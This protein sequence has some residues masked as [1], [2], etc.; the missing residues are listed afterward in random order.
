MQRQEE[1]ARTI[2][3][4]EVNK[5]LPKQ[6]PYAKWKSAKA[7]LKFALKNKDKLVLLAS[8]C[9]D[10]ETTFLYLVAD[11]PVY[12]STTDLY[13]YKN[14]ELWNAYFAQPEPEEG[15][16]E[17]EYYDPN[18]PY[19]PECG[20]TDCLFFQHHTVKVVFDT[21][22]LPDVKYNLGDISVLKEPLLP[23]ILNRSV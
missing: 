11:T 9:G 5:V 13:I 1:L 4:A 17:A 16:E 10:C 7:M 15:S 19:C 3:L 6:F 22:G 20:E 2:T 23:T 12:G 21:S 8:K 18:E 14:Y